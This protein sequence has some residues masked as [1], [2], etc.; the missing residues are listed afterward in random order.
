MVERTGATFYRGQEE[1]RNTISGVNTAAEATIWFSTAS[2]EAPARLYGHFARVASAFTR[3]YTS[4]PT[5]SY[6]C[7]NRALL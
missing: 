5:A 1:V 2:M 3:V 4:T 7:K 6:Q